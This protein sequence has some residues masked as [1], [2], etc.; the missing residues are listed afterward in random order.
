MDQILLGIPNTHCYLDDILITGRNNGEHLKTLDQ[1]LTRLE[2]YGL[3]L[4]REKY[5]FFRQSL[6][7]LGHYIDAAGL[8]KSP[9]K[10][11]AIMEVHALTNVSQLR[12]FL[13]MINYYGRFIPNLASVLNPL[14]ALLCKEKKWCWSLA[15]EQSFQKVKD[16]LTSPAVLTHYDP[17]LPICLACDA[18]PYGVGAVISHVCPDGEEKPIAFA[19]RTLSIAEQNYA[20]I[21]R[22]AL[23]IIFGIRKFHQY[24]YGRRF[25]LFTNHQHLTAFLS[26]NKG[27]PSMAA[28]RMQ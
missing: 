4:Q 12:S 28:A 24:L 25:T 11:K 3:R 6:E 13:G 27:I 19:S 17:E 2:E 1:V 21:E 10:I 15:C 5:E 14:N 22:E 16:L 26:P 23:S 7:Y 20:Q 18:S 9:E 8:H